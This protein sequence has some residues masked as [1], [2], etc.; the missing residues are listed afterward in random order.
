MDKAESLA[1]LKKAKQR[2]EVVERKPSPVLAGRNKVPKSEILIRSL[3][4]KESTNQISRIER[5]AQKG[6]GAQESV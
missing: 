3:E 4:A 6:R 5:S 2:R 1:K